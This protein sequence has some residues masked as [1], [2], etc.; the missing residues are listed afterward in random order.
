[1]WAS[2]NHWDQLPK[3]SVSLQP[4]FEEL[5]MKIFNISLMWRKDSF[6]PRSVKKIVYCD[7]RDFYTNWNICWKRHAFFIEEKTLIR[8]QNKWKMAIGCVLIPL[9]WSFKSHVHKISRFWGCYQWRTCDATTLLF[10]RFKGQFC[11]FH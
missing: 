11:C 3:M 5:F 6:C 8:K 7:L 1:M 2:R 10:T 4:E 9:P